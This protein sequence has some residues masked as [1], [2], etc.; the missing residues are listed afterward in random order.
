MSWVGSLLADLQSLLQEVVPLTDSL[1][2]CSDATHLATALAVSLERRSGVTR[3]ATGAREVFW[4]A[5]EDYARQ[6]KAASPDGLLNGIHSF[7]ILSTAPTSRPKPCTSLP[8][9]LLLTA[10]KQAS[11]FAKRL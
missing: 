6:M 11:F 5:L 10:F 4:I 9:K 3:L 7:Q 8:R 1:E 2:R